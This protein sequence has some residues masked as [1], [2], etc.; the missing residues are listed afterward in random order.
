MRFG[1]RSICFKVAGEE[2]LEEIVCR[3]L[4]FLELLDRREGT[5]FLDVEDIGDSD[6]CTNGFDRESAGLRGWSDG[7]GRYQ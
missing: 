3:V 6:C 1:K 4:F 2:Y 5:E 7:Y